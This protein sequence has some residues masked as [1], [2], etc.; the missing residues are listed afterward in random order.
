MEKKELQ[1]L[2]HDPVPGYKPVFFVVFAL[3]LIY[4]GVVFFTTM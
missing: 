2:S 4:L 1:E 3:S